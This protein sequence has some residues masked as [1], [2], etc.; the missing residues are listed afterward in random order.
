MPATAHAVVGRVMVVVGLGAQTEAGKADSIDKGPT[1]RTWQA[2]R[3]LAGVN[4]MG[5]WDRQ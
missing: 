1:H 3:L 2:N 5:K 4:A